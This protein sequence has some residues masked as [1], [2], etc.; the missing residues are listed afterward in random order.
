MDFIKKRLPLIICFITGTLCFAQYYVPHPV[1]RSFMEN[2]NRTVLIMGFFAYL[3]G[4]Y[5][6][7]TPH[8][9]NILSQRAGWGYSAVLFIGLAIGAGTGL[10]SRAQALS[11]DGALTC[12]GWM[13]TYML[14]P[15]QGTIYS[16]LG[17][18]IVSTAYRA[19]RIKNGQAF[20]L[21]AAA[22]VLVF[23]RVPLGQLIWNDLLGWTGLSIL[24]IVE[25]VLNVPDVAGR[26]GIMIGIALGAIATSVK[27]ITGVEKKYLGGD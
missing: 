15:L 18:Y 21:F 5:S 26:R 22:A 10:A 3:L 1:A 8:L 7:V 13:Y 24:E 17:F 14:Y 23:G 4:L 2:A 12:F 27:I 16:L 11:P 6:I 25:W 20:L 9:K 19:F